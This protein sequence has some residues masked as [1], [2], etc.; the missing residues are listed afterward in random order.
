[1]A[2]FLNAQS[3]CDIQLTVFDKKSRGTALRCP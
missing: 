1:M 2:E 3:Y